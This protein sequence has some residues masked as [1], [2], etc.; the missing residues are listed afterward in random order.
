MVFG[1]YDKF[2]HKVL[3]MASVE[4][5][6]GQAERQARDNGARS[7]CLYVRIINCTIMTRLHYANIIMLALLCHPRALLVVYGEQSYFFCESLQ[8]L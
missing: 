6:A 2:A 1:S 8:G 7:G 5:V 4:V 3:G